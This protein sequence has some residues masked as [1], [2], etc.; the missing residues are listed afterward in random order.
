MQLL[1]TVSPL[2]G[3][4]AVTVQEPHNLACSD[5]RL[6]GIGCILNA[7]QMAAGA[8]TPQPDHCAPLKFSF[9]SST[10]L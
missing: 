7:T 8:P 9:V 4:L 10:G 6:Q 1:K 3:S 2:L 5:V